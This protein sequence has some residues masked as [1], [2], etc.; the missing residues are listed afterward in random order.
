MY[1]S[2]YALDRRLPPPGVAVREVTS[3][4]R[5]VVPGVRLGKVP[6][7]LIFEVPEFLFKKGVYHWPKEASCR[8][9]PQLVQTSR[10]LKDTHRAIAY[11]APIVARGKRARSIVSWFFDLLLFVAE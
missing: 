3:S 9:K 1:V 6:E 11:T 10:F 7:S 5:K 4:A 8:K 2:Y